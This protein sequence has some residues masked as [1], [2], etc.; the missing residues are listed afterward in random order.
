M[1]TQD[2]VL[3][4]LTVY[5]TPSGNYDGSSDTDFAGDRQK[6]VGYYR[7]SSGT[8]SVMFD[9]NDFIG[10]IKIQGSLDDDPTADSAWFD[11][12]TFPDDS[13]ATSATVSVALTGNFAWL[14]AKV[15]GFLGGTINSVLLTY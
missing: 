11:V 12:Y 7:R 14:R 9:V 10:E 2:L 15:T 8:Q 6:G 1:K 13:A 3:L 4:P 5:G